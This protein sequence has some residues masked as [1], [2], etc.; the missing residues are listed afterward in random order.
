[1][2][3]RKWLKFFLTALLIGAVTTVITS[4]VVQPY[5][6]SPYLDPFNLWELTGAVFWFV[7]W[8][9][10]YSVI[11]QA[12]FFAYL[13]INQ[14]G[15][16]FFGFFWKHVQIL[17]ILVVLFDLVYLRYTNTADEGSLMSYIIVT[18][19]LLI[20]SYAVAKIKVK[21][22]HPRAFLPALF[23][24]IVVT[25]VEWIPVLRVG[26]TEWIMLMI[27]PLLACNTYQLLTLHR[28]VGFNEGPAEEDNTN[29]KKKKGSQ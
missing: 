15:R 20:I 26:E 18:A 1:M 28:I 8:G 23:F 7:V 14:F 24:M 25:T 2:T 21:E 12:G 19:L 5:A 6:Y 9:L 4:F 27:V 10:V 29:N 3:I 22:T 11:S 16:G 13:T 17:L